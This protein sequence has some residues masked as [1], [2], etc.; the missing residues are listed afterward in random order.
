MLLMAFQQDALRGNWMK[1]FRI[2]HVLVGLAV[3]V[4]LAACSVTS[5]PVTPGN[6]EQVGDGVYLFQSGGHRSLFMI[7]DEGVIVTDPLNTQAARSY[8]AAIAALT[9]QPVKFVVYSHYHWDR[10]SGAEVFTAE[11]AQVV[12]QARCAERFVDNPNPN[13]VMPD[14]T[15]DKEYKV[16]LGGRSLDLYYFGPSH[17]DCLTIMVAQP[18]GLMQIVDLVEPPRASFPVDRYASYIKPHNLLEFFEQ[19]RSLVMR[20]GT[21]EVLASHVRL[22]DD[23]QGGT[24]K[25]PPT[26]PA[27]IIADQA[28]FWNEIYAAVETAREQGNIGI[29]S[30]VKLKTLDTKPF[31]GFDGYNKEDLPIIMRRVTGFYDMG[32]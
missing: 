14:I 6:T 4:L 17:G 20:T 11:G 16:S 29:D 26:A 31:E 21:T 25:S 2:T 32:R 22:I 19:A 27:L 10:V 3:A 23:G 15:F 30:F 24:I 28:R 1:T 8:R 7:T 5:S 9:D 18:A 13:V 12:A